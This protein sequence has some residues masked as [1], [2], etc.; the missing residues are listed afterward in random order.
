MPNPDY[1]KTGGTLYFSDP[2]VDL[3][4]SD[5]FCNDIHN[6]ICWFTYHMQNIHPDNHIGLANFNAFIALQHSQKNRLGPLRKM[7]S[8][9]GP[10]RDATFEETFDSEQRIHNF[11]TSAA[12]L[13]K[14][15]YN[16]GRGLAGIDLDYENPNMTHEQSVQYANLVA[17]LRTTLNKEIGVGR[18][19]L[20][21]SILSDPGY[22]L[23]TSGNNTSG[24][25]R[26]SLQR[27]A[28]NVDYIAVN[29]FNFSGPF[30]YQPNGVGRTGFIINLYTEQ[31]QP[32]S[33][34]R[35]LSALKQVVGKRI[36]NKRIIVSLPA[37]GYALD[38][39]PEKNHGLFQ[40]IPAD[41]K[42]LKGNI[43][44]QHCR[45][46]LP[47]THDACSGAFS[48]Q[49]LMNRMINKGFK[50]KLWTQKGVYNGATAYAA[51]WKAQP[52]TD[53]KKPQEILYNNVFLSFCAPELAASITQYVIKNNYG[54]IMLWEMNGDM[55]FNTG[56][57]S[58]SLLGTVVKTYE[59]SAAIPFHKK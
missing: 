8:I 58:L 26:D 11:V 47:A 35:T 21:I 17:A 23:G 30:N 12:R 49:Y 4:G 34:Q 19:L 54:G 22:I 45:Q 20:T 46:S 10:D 56:K 38:N 1:E 42:I 48:Y 43:D 50:P 37:F 3:G 27:I 32:H 57:S 15:F 13:I 14:A 25:T 41:S 29:T 16:R 39:I 44:M 33:I 55:P 40:R 6:S 28:Q 59:S 36:P 52:E 31:H 7:I 51:H 18:Y 5:A 2:W 9:G 24:F 53:A